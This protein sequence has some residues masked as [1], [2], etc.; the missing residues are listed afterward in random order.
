MHEPARL[1]VARWATDRSCSV[2]EVG[3]REETGAIR[4]LFPAASWLGIDVR[5]GP[6]V[7]LV[8]DGSTWTPELGV[9]DFAISTEVFEHAWKWRSI[10]GIMVAALRPGGRLIVTCAGPNR[11]PHSAVDGGPW[12][13]PDE[14]YCPV[15]PSEM[16]RQLRLATL[17]DLE[18]ESDDDDVFATAV[19][20]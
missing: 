14:W 16:R 13:G 3:S 6:N 15:F 1:F 17:Y 12:V 11:R 8:A 5:P 7:D 2:Y 20:R 9:Y 10:L 19:R 18:V 4:A